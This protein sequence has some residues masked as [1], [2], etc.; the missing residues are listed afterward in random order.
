MDGIMSMVRNRRK[1]EKPKSTEQLAV[2]QKKKEQEDKEE[3]ELEKECEKWCGIVCKIAVVVPLIFTYL[4]HPLNEFATRPAMNVETNVNLVGVNAIVTGGCSGMG[5]HTAALMVE[6]GASVVVGCRDANGDTAV[7]AAARLKA[8]S[9]RWG[10]N[11]HGSD[12]QP[13]Q[14]WQLRLDRFSSVRSFA[15]RYIE[16]GNKLQLLLNNAGTT[17]ACNVTGDGIE[18]AFQANYLG[19]FLLTNLLLPTIKKSSPSRV[20]HVTCREGYMRAAHGYGQSFRDGWFAGWL[21]LPTPI[22][23]PI[24]VGSTYVESASRSAIPEDEENAGHEL[25]TEGGDW[26]EASEEEDMDLDTP[27]GA[28]M[29]KNSSLWT[30]RCHPADAYANAKLAVLTFSHELERRLRA[31]IDSDG[32]VSHAVNP[33]VVDTDFFEKAAALAPARANRAM[34]YLP[35]VWIASKVFGFF[36]SRLSKAMMR[37]VEHGAKGIFHV[38]TSTSIDHVGGG[39]FDDTE[40]AFVSCGRAPEMCGRVHRSWQPAVALDRTAGAK[41]WELSEALTRD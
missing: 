14:I 23:E 25:V 22:K 18:T 13:P 4:L 9:S 1:P 31:S 6:S 12:L 41:L 20:V 3:E 2:E 40:S 37:S 36:H 29:K 27:R 16:S 39:L 28:A 11:N 19:H 30:F 8:A 21:G 24:R 15:Q 32:V 35:P 26:E 5:L 33:N 38:A 7:K 17:D 10:K 34:S